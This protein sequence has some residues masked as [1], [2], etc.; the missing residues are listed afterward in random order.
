MHYALFFAIGFL[1]GALFGVV[2]KIKTRDVVKGTIKTLDKAVVAGERMKQA[3]VRTKDKAEHGVYAAENAPEEYAADRVSGGVETAAYEA[4]HQ[5][6]KRG[7]KAVKTT[8][9]KGRHAFIVCTHVDKAHIHNHI[10]CAPIRG[11][12]NPL[13]RRQA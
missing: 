13:S 2:L 12:V 1:I 3:Y 10:I 7:R 4:A 11:R 9:D 5:L 6:D 8:K